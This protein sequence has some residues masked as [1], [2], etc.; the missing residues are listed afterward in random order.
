MLVITLPKVHLDTSSTSSEPRQRIIRA[1]GNSVYIDGK[2]L[3]NQQAY[4]EHG[5]S[6]YQLAILI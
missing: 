4:L 6:V 3:N 2:R 5:A 1:H